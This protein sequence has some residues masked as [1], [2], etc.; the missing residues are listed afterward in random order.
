MAE[1][2]EQEEEIQKRIWATFR[3]RA[4]QIQS[5]SLP[6]FEVD[7]DFPPRP[8]ISNDGVAREAW[9]EPAVPEFR[10]HEYTDLGTVKSLITKYKNNPSYR[11]K[12]DKF[13]GLSLKDLEKLRDEILLR[14]DGS[15]PLPGQLQ[16]GRKRLRPA[17]P[18][19]RKVPPRTALESAV[20][21]RRVSID[22]RESEDEQEFEG[23]GF[24]S[25]NWFNG[26][27]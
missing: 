12:R 1:V 14:R 9:E 20:L 7:D 10:F 27:T 8:P 25:E 18:K 16:E 17:P 5:P 13:K 2:A 11:V 19:Q 6:Y 22:P 4:L 21:R 24:V 26:F 23:E 15:K 3:G